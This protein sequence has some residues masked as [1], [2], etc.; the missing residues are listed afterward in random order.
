MSKQDNINETWEVRI[1]AL[2]DGELNPQEV[3]AL[4]SEAQHDADLAQ[5]IID[6][7]AL[8][9]GLDELEIERA[10]A[11]LR[12]RLAEIPGAEKKQSA[13]KKQPTHWFGMPRWVS[14]GALAAVP[15]L[16][17]A[18]VMM[19]SQPE[20]AEQPEFTEAEILQARQD[21]I[22]AFAYLDRIGDRAGRQI[23]SEIS[24]ELSSGV[25]RNVTRYMPYTNNSLQEE[26]S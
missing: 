4:K 22:V 25:N 23:E 26:T 9:S 16:V 18:M 19:Q 2:L 13:E 15:L 20:L 6:A 24:E 3:E 7:Y 10:P 21:V 1:N 12:S 8:Q 5:A 17:I 11:S 14:A